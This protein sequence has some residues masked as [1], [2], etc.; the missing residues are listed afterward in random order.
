[1]SIQDS[2]AE[3]LDLLY[4]R[5]FNIPDQ[6]TAMLDLS[7]TGTPTKEWDKD[8]TADIGF[9]FEIGNQVQ[10]IN[11]GVLYRCI[12]NEHGNA[13]WSIIVQEKVV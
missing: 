6:N 13:E 4:K 9:K 11:N 3:Q 7:I 5:K 2:T 12:N 1:M 10:D 8:D